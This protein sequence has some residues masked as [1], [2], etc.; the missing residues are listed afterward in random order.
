VTTWPPFQFQVPSPTVNLLPGVAM[1]AGSTITMSGP[2]G[3]KQIAPVPP[4][5]PADVGNYGAVLGES[6]GLY[7]TP[8]SSYTL[9]GQ[10][11][12]NVGAFTAA[13]E[14]P[15]TLTWTNQSSIG[16]ITRANGVTV[17]WS[18]ADPNGYIIISGGSPGAGFN[19]TANPS[20]GHFAV[21]PV[22]LLP[23]P[24]SLINYSDGYAIDEGWLQIG[25]VTQPAVFQAAGL[26]IA[27]A[28]AS[29][30]ISQNLL[31]Q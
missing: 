10:G 25:S 11:G 23:L 24:P 13:L 29:Y 27:Q 8:G 12:K 9:T 1:D 17:T 3:P 22:V 16:N 30:L 20:A 15:Q 6:N 4:P 5:F 31:Y 14:M 28:T 7:L 19:C 26:G 2:N 18:G 21:P